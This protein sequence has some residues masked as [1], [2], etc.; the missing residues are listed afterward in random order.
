MNIWYYCYDIEDKFHFTWKNFRKLSKIK[1]NF[2]EKLS[3]LK[4]ILKL[5]EKTQ[6]S[7]KHSNFRHI[8]TLALRKRWPKNKPDLSDKLQH[9]VKKALTSSNV[10][11]SKC[12]NQLFGLCALC[13]G[14]WHDVLVNGFNCSL[15]A[16]ELH[17]GVRNLKRNDKSEKSSFQKISSSVSCSL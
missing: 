4:N 10:T 1:K 8:H 14:L 7:R 2:W 9:G 15:E 6:N 13:S 16:S 3:K 12:D 17:H 11:S 5:K